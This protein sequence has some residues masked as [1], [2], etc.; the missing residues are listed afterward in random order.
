M[1]DK[2]TVL[3]TGVNSVHTPMSMPSRICSICRKPEFP[4]AIMSTEIGW[5]C[6]ECA[7]RIKRMIYPEVDNGT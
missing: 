1:A 5:I 7:S 6:P 3:H 2:V 4:N